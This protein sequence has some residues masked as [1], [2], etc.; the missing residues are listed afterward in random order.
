MVSQR[1]AGVPMEC[2]AILAVPGEPDGGVTC[3]VSHQAPH[4]AH[5]A[6]APVLGLEPEQLRVALPVGRRR[7]RPEGRGVRRVHRRGQGG[8]WRSAGR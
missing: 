3:W 2:N 1:L 6:L 8:A 4:A 5:G 7:L